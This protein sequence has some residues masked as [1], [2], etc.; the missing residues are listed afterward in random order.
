MLWFFTIFGMLCVDISDRSND[1]DNELSIG[2]ATYRIAVRMT[3]MRFKTVKM[4]P[5]TIKNFATVLF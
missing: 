4:S 3:E 2:G 1:S 5:K